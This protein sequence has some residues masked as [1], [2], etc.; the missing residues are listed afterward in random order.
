MIQHGAWKNLMKQAPAAPDEAP[1][2][3]P[4]IPPMHGGFLCLR[5][6][7]ANMPAQVWLTPPRASDNLEGRH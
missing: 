3:A 7:P 1:Q 6:A 5:K 2:F 4:G